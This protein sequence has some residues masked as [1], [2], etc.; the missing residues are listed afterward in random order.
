MPRRRPGATPPIPLPLAT[1]ARRRQGVPE[2]V[3]PREHRQ[4]VP[5][6]GQNAPL[7]VPQLGSC[8]SS[9]HSWRLWAARHSQE[10]VDPLSALPLPRVL[11]Q[12]ASKAAD[13]TAFVHPVDD[14]DDHDDDDDDDDDEL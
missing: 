12:A 11:D 2:G 7:A 14:D 9:G 13:V 5:Q 1:Q 4:P 6:H 8:A 10:E 3:V